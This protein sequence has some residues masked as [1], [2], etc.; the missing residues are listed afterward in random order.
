MRSW[1]G[2]VTHVHS[3]TFRF[4]ATALGSRQ[5]IEK[6]VPER[7]LTCVLESFGN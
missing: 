5:R 4:R 2:R 6:A 1:V 7:A 3:E